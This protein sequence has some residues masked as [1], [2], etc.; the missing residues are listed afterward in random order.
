MG[1]ISVTYTG[2]TCLNWKDVPPDS[3]P[4]SPPVTLANFSGI[5]TLADVKN[6]C[7][8]PNLHPHGP[9]CLTLEKD[10]KSYG[11][12]HCNIPKFCRKCTHKLRCDH[13]LTFVTCPL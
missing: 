1:N 3:Q 7:R 6:Y 13:S 5:T 9:W 12:E 8:N 2:T 4:L 11:H 10:G